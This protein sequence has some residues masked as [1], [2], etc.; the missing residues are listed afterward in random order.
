MIRWEKLDGHAGCDQRILQAVSMI[1]DVVGCNIGEFGI[2]GGERFPM[3]LMR[4][5]LP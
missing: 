3:N 2:L 4:G 1:E 5:V